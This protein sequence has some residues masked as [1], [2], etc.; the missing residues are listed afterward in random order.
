MIENLLLVPR[1]SGKSVQL[2]PALVMMVLVIGGQ[3]AGFW[4]M[5]IAV[6]LT[7]I[8]RDVFLYL[9]L[10]LLDEP[11]SPQDAVARLRSEEKVVLEA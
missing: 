6:P 7:A 3:L 1:I 2:H 11:L 8:I 10:R 5:L 9:Y 4:G